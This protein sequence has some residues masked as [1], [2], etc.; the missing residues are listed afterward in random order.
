M[1]KESKKSIVI[2]ILIIIIIL[3]LGFMVYYYFTKIN[4][5]ASTIDNEYVNGIKTIHSQEII[6]NHKRY[7]FM[8]TKDKKSNYYVTLT[9]DKKVTIYK[10]SMYVS[11]DYNDIDLANNFRAEI[12]YIPTKQ[13]DYNYFILIYDGDSEAERDEYIIFANKDDKYQ[14]LVNLG[15]ITSTG[16]HIDNQKADTFL[17]QDDAIYFHDNGCGLSSGVDYNIDYSKEPGYVNPLNSTSD[18]LYQIP[19]LKLKLDGFNYSF[20]F[21][22]FDMGTGAGA[23]C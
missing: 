8:I 17:I 13:D 2:T 20:E 7:Y 3:L 4:K 15:Y 19:Y 21:I 16:Y 5:K 9:N 18:G 10:H 14:Q 12:Q 22:K 1:E 11:D 23:R 6:A